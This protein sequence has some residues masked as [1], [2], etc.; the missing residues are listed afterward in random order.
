MFFMKRIGRVIKKD[1]ELISLV[2]DDDSSCSGCLD[3]MEE[4]ALGG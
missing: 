2:L 3:V 4:N 1:H